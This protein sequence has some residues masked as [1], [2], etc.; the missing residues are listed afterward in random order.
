MEESSPAAH[1]TN[2]SGKDGAQSGEPVSDVPPI[3]TDRLLLRAFAPADAE[4]VFAYSS[5]PRI[6]H[7]A[8]WPAHRSLDDSL[9]FI[10]DIASQGHVWALVPKETIRPETPQG[11]PIG[12]IGLIADPARE[13]DR[14]LMLGYAIGAE[15][16]GK[17]YTT[18]ASIAVLAYRF[19]A[20]EL[21]AVSCTCYPWNKASKRVIDKCGFEYEG[22]RHLAEIGQDG[23][24]EDFLCHILT[25]KRWLDTCQAE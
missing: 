5:D 21:A 22:C 11:T 16:W 14:V 13:Y 19:D 15:F 7:D 18:E 8:G 10:R 9:F 6:G 25:K 24:P 1:A 3:K 20:L 12:S 2:Q 4:A 23:V 17:G